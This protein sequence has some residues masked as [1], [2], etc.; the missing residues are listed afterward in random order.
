MITEMLEGLLS[1]AV[2]PWFPFLRDTALLLQ[3]AVSSALLIAA[4]LALRLLLGGKL[5]CRLR[6]ALWAAVLLRLLVP[7]QMP[8]SLPISAAG[9]APEVPQ[10]WTEPAAASPYGTAEPGSAYSDEETPAP[11]GLE[12]AYG[13]DLSPASP[14]SGD[15]ILYHADGVSA[16]ELLQS[17]WWTGVLIA[18]AAL[19][20]C[21]L[22][23]ALRLER[24]RR[25]VAVEGYP[26]PIYEADGLASPCLFGLFWPAVYLTPEAGADETIRAHVL[27]HEL[28][29]YAHLDHVWALLRCL[30]LALHWYN[31]LVWAAVVL[32]KRDG[33]LACDEGAVARLGEEQRVSYGRTLVDMVAHRGPG[34]ADLLSCS[35]TMKA[36]KRAMRERIT[37]LVKHPHT[38]KTALFTAVA[39]VALSVVFVFAGQAEAEPDLYAQYLDRLSQAQAIQVVDLPYS[40]AFYSA[41]IT[42]GD[43]LEEAKAILGAAEPTEKTSVDLDQ[44]KAALLSAG[45]T[46]VTGAR[47]ENQYKYLLYH[48]DGTTYVVIPADAGV[49][50]YMPIAELDVSPDALTGLIKRQWQNERGA[51]S[52]EDP[53]PAVSGPVDA[54]TVAM[55]EEGADAQEPAGG[56]PAAAVDDTVS[57][58]A[59]LRVT[60][61][62]VL[63]DKLAYWEKCYPDTSPT[64]HLTGFRKELEYND[65]LRDGTVCVYAYDYGFENYGS[66]LPNWSGVP[67]T[68]GPW[69]DENGW[70]HEYFTQP[71][72]LTVEKDGQVARYTTSQQNF[73]ALDGTWDAAAALEMVADKLDDL[74]APSDFAGSADLQ[75]TAEDYG[76]ALADYYLSVGPGH[77][78][79]AASAQVA[80]VEFYDRDIRRSIVEI[81]LAV[82]PADPDSSCWT[83]QTGVQ[84]QEN[85]QWAGYWLCSYRYDADMES[86]GNWYCSFVGAGVEPPHTGA[87]GSDISVILYRE[88]FTPKSSDVDMTAVLDRQAGKLTWDGENGPLDYLSMDRTRIYFKT[89][90][91]IPWDCETLEGLAEAITSDPQD[92]SQ[93]LRVYADGQPVSGTATAKQSG[94]DMT[95]MIFQFVYDK[96]FDY[97]SGFVIT[98]E[99]GPVD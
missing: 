5:S 91:L 44:N 34:P 56:A 41:S 55:D 90:D 1:W 59:A 99:L 19:L 93:W 66:R 73:T 79:A 60:V 51:A 22:R 95:G 26:I 62:Q 98:M 10:T 65:L 96:P 74:L 84:Y 72:L 35:T 39:V 15:A 29:H 64:I 53:E 32:S 33:E 14:N 50:N 24:R 68:G 89:T 4:V 46:L 58:P 70:F 30:C 80:R 11:D 42:D 28:T 48:Q 17:V 82:K 8:V 47:E 97:A 12:T 85:G 87:T 52:A 16:E 57:V 3:W 45:I 9:L 78:K 43:L 63:A 18:G 38:V 7:F 13:D 54:A 6:Y 27:A 61:E 94:S 21:N 31:P 77:P 69:V 81:T 83:N 25:L 92:V 71:C 67:G 75:Q 23:F 76:E 2:T 37:Q 36:G 86:D 88:H 40:S 20:A 49:S